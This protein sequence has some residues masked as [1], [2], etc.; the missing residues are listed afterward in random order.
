[1]ARIERKVDRL[2]VGQSRIIHMEEEEMADLSAL[3]AEVTR[4]TEVDQSAI[5][6]LTGLAAQIEA[7]KTD[8]AALQVLA[9]QLKGSSDSLAA[10][11]VA[12]T[13]SA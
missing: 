10:A 1:M 11:V 5:A 12:N 6:L 13:P 8:P 3:T 2:V 9:D 4:N 7:L